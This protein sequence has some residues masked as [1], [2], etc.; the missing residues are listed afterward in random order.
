MIS[1]VKRL[2]TIRIVRYGLVG[3]VGIFINE[4]ALFC[5]MCLLGLAISSAACLDVSRTT[6]H[7]ILRRFAEEQFAGLADVKRVSSTRRATHASGTACFM[8]S[9][10]WRGNGPGGHFS[11]CVDS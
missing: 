5:F 8:G 9:E 7:D 11:R 6:V 10:T 4:G 3:G 2:L 1:L